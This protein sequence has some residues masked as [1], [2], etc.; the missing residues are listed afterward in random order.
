MPIH[1]KTFKS[2]LGDTPKIETK[3]GVRSTGKV[4][5]GAGLYLVVG[6]GKQRSWMY[7]YNFGGAGKEI[8]LGSAF[9]VDLEAARAKRGEYEAL[10]DKGIDPKA[11]KDELRR[12]LAATVNKI[13]RR[14]VYELAKEAVFVIGPKDNKMNPRKTEAYR[15]AWTA[16]LRPDQTAGLGGKAPADVTRQDVIACIEAIQ[17]RAPSGFQAEKVQQQL[18]RFFDWCR[19]PRQGHLPIT[20]ENPADFRDQYRFDLNLKPARVVG[21]AAIPYDQIGATLAVIRRH[22]EMVNYV[23]RNAGEGLNLARARFD[24]FCLEWTLLSAVRVSNSIEADWSEFDFEAKLWTIPPWKM[25]VSTVGPHIVP[26]TQRHLDILK[27]VAPEGDWPKTGLVFPS[28]LGGLI[29]RG[30]MLDR[31]R[32]ADDGLIVRE[33]GSERQAS[34]HGFRSAFRTWAEEQTNEDTGLPLYPE[35]ILEGCLAHVVGDRAQRAYQ[36]GI[37]IKARC[38]VLTAWVKYLEAEVAKVNALPKAA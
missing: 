22:Q 12:A 10:L 34:I 17:K 9:K 35:Q 21:Q 33:D 16:R 6:A 2:L 11:N 3:E 24:D 14:T 20:A 7:R 23:N 8:A 18:K 38:T 29:N 25:K 15:K 32:R 26:L 13:E 30:Q 5:D 28:A 27:R 1:H 19:S 4:H 31:L 36:R 37:N